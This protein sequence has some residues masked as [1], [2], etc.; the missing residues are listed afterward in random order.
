MAPDEGQNH[1][2]SRRRFLHG[3]AGAAGLLGWS[4]L[5]RPRAARGAQ[6]GAADDSPVRC[7]MPVCI[8]SKHLQWLDYAGMAKLAAEIGFDGIDL[9]VRPGGH[10]L[11]ERVEEDLPKAVEAAKAAGLSIPMMVTGIIEPDDPA[12]ATILKTAAACGIRYYRLGSYAYT[13]DRELPAQVAEIA[14]KLRLL[15]AMN[16]QYR[17]HGAYQNH[18]GSGRFGACVWD[19]WQAIQQ[20]DPRWLGCQF[21]IRHATVEGGQAWPTHVFLIAPHVVTL[22]AKDFYWAKTSSTWQPQNC[23]L[24]EGMVSWDRFGQ[25]AKRARLT[26]PVSLHLEY[27]LGGAEHGRRTISEGDASRVAA[28]MRRDLHALRAILSKAGL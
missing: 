24:G 14:A 1:D 8:F 23:P 17:L 9:T 10:V 3:A 20:I 18:C 22:A 2:L 26:G 27:D 28:A 25:M 19:L 5:A 4:A 21:D 15:A 16:E 13:Y 12:T 6:A 7:A 11:P